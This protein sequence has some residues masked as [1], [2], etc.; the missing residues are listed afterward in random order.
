[1]SYRFDGEVIVIT[2]A[3][4]G[5]GRATAIKLAALGAFLAL[6]DIDDAGANATGKMLGEY[7]VVPPSTDVSDADAVKSV[8]SK[9]VD[10]AK[11]VAGAD[12]ISHVFNCA[13]INPTA[14]DIEDTADG[15]WDRLMDVNVKGI[16]NM[17]KACLPYMSRNSSFVNVSSLCGLYPRSRLAIYCA[18]KY[19]VIGFSKCMAL[20]L[21]ERGIRTNVVAPGDIDTPTNASVVEG[22]ESMRRAAEGTAVGR[23]GT[24]EE[25][26]DVVAFLMGEGARYVNG[27]VVEVN[28]GLRG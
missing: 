10:L 2:G 27:S 1:M 20:E 25:V 15:Y 23:M 3:A 9:I 17:T 8:V 21:G 19:A 16:Y 11:G 5:I 13:G 26:A 18:T 28:G 14:M 7:Y 24:P 22:E 4:S 6:I 12:G